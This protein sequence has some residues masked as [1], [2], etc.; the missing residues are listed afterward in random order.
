MHHFPFPEKRL[1]RI[2]VPKDGGCRLRSHRMMRAE[3]ISE[4]N[5]MSIFID[6]R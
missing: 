6:Y 2:A 1:Y 4:P 5:R 3:P